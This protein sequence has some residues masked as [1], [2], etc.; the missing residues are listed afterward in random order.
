MM[1]HVGAVLGAWFYLL[2][3]GVHAEGTTITPQ[4]ADNKGELTEQVAARL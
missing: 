2:F 1:P 4:S 3:V